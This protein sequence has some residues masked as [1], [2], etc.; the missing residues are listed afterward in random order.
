MTQRSYRTIT[1]LVALAA[2]ASQV[3]GPPA[4]HAR[5]VMDRSYTIPVKSSTIDVGDYELGRHETRDNGNTSVILL[6][7]HAVAP[8]LGSSHDI[9]F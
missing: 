9:F 7:G 3:L 2:L 6:H 4:Q 5:R 8:S 1:I